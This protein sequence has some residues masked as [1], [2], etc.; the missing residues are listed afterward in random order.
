VTALPITPPEASGPSPR[1]GAKNIQINPTLSWTA[2]SNAAGHNVYFGADATAVEN[3]SGASDPTVTFTSVDVARF[4]PTVL[5]FNST[6]YWRVDEVNDANAEK[7][8]KGPVWSFTTGNFYVVDDF[9]SYTNDSPNRVFQTWIDGWPFSPDEFFPNGG[10]GN[11]T[12]A[13]I[14]SDPSFGNIMELTSVHGGKQ[15]VP[16]AYDNTS[17][18][19]VSE[20]QRTWSQPQDWAHDGGN[21]LVLYI[22]G[23]A[24]NTTDTLYVS[25]TDELGR[26]KAV[27]NTDAGILTG[28]EWTQ[29]SI[30][31][32]AFTDVDMSRVK[33]IVIGLGTGTSSSH[34]YGMIFIDDI[35]VQRLP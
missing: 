15:S 6:Y 4:S 23:R 35:T 9:E 17:P 20:A 21:T 5:D 27:Q 30:P 2:G 10:P 26:S 14:G 28:T 7:L 31:F 19:Y 25:I 24:G 18:P 34:G 8:W 1:N 22:L 12:G 32:S 29:W 11:G 33:S 3:A 13:T 16:L